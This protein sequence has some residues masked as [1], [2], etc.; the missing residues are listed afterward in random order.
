MIGRR[1]AN[2]AVLPALRA[3]PF[4][5]H[6]QGPAVRAAMVA[7]LAE[8]RAAARVVI[9]IRFLDQPQLEQL[10][11][12]ESPAARRARSSPRCS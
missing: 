11:A 7:C 8:A 9:R 1:E 10:V 4:H 3:K 5:W 2:R 12:T 6:R